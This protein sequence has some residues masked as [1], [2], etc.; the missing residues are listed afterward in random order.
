MY[1]YIC[2]KLSAWLYETLIPSNKIVKCVE[3]IASGQGFRPWGQYDHILKIYFKILEIRLLCFYNVC[4]FERKL[5]TW[6]MILMNIKSSTKTVKIMGP[7]SI[8]CSSLRAGIYGHLVKMYW[9]LEKS[10]SL[11]P[12]DW[13]IKRMHDYDVHKA[14]YLN[15]K[16]HGVW[17]SDPKVR[18]YIENVFDSMLE[19]FLLN[20]HKW[21]IWE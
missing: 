8:R 2:E 15:C 20:F 16:I 6:N 5:T 13:K 17:V 11:L 18:P 3:C 14:F 19:N 21:Y 7:V 12:K 10:S 4:T 1:I 9:I